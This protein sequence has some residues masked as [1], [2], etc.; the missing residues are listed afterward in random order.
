LEDAAH[1]A[2]HLLMPEIV[3]E[4][5]VKRLWASLPGVK[6]IRLTLVGISD[7]NQGEDQSP[8]N[9]LSYSDLTAEVIVDIVDSET[10]ELLYSFGS[11]T[12]ENGNQFM[13]IKLDAE[14][15][16]EGA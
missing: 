7:K 16:L 8:G 13:T 5:G 1:L 11:M 3:T 10:G 9:V 12:L 4:E 15:E 14:V 2:K 6:S